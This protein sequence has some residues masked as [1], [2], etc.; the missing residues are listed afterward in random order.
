MKKLLIIAAVGLVL[1]ACTTT[2][3]VEVERVSHDTTYI[4]KLVFDSI[5]MHDSVYVSEKGDTIR[6]EKWHTKYIEREVHDTTYVSKTDSVPVPYPVIK[7]VPRELTW[8]QK[9]Q[10]YTGDALL[11]GLLVVG[12]GWFIG[13]RLWPK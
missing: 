13:T 8:W 4:S 7:E 1:T 12:A 11:I 9:M 2:R 6:I 10:M 3:V 5:Y